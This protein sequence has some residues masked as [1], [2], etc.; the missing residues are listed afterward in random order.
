MF[1]C[2]HSLAMGIYGKYTKPVTIFSIIQ[3]VAG[4]LM[5]GL[6]I[7][8]RVLVCSWI[9]DIAFGF[10]VG[11]LVCSSTV[12]TNPTLSLFVVS[13]ST[14]KCEP[15]TSGKL[16][17][18]KLFFMFVYVFEFAYFVCTWLSAAAPNWILVKMRR[19]EKERRRTH[20][21]NMVNRNLCLV[22]SIEYC[23]YGYKFSLISTKGVWKER[24]RNG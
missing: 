2:R 1:S 22:W 9:T 3:M 14:I 18:K 8:H 16:F 21:E 20:I 15:V 4:V 7:A 10:W 6:G 24:K 23:S 12:V 11:L 5:I 13:R 17:D 19:F